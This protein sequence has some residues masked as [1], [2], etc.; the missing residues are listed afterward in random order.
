MLE[1]GS[2]MAFILLAEKANRQL[3]YPRGP[4]GLVSLHEASDQKSQMEIYSPLA[5]IRL[6]LVDPTII[7]CIVI[8]LIY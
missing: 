8:M 4:S 6:T 3:S 7:V 1:K 5:N 2:E